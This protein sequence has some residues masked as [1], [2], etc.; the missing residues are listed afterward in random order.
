MLVREF[1]SFERGANPKKVL[2]IGDNIIVYRQLIL[3]E[4]EK[5]RKKYKIELEVEILIDKKDIFQACIEIHR[6]Y[7][8]YVYSLLYD[9]DAL[10]F[11]V[12]KQDMRTTSG[13]Y[14]DKHVSTLEEAIKII[15][16]WIKKDLAK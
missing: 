16:G 14:P 9:T 3:E 1:I 8:Q 4:L 12:L 15:D 11:Y 2:G 7:H 13:Y 5:L 6:Y 10:D